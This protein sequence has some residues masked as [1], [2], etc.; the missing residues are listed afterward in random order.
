MTSATK[1]TR[2]SGLSR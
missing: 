2:K 1:V